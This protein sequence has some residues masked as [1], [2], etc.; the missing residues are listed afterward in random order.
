MS[1]G[2]S[3]NKPRIERVKVQPHNAAARAKV[4]HRV[5]LF[6]PRKA[7]EQNRVRREFIQPFALVDFI[8][9]YTQIFFNKH[10]YSRRRKAF[11]K[12]CRHIN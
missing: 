2:A 7:G 9:V 10:N 1:V 12:L 4:R 5:A 3:F 6:Y 8:A 11:D